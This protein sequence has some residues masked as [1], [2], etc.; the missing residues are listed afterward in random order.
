MSRDWNSS[1]SGLGHQSECVAT[2]EAGYLAFGTTLVCLQYAW[3]ALPAPAEYGLLNLKAVIF[4]TATFAWRKSYS[5]LPAPLLNLASI[6]RALQP[7]FIYAK[8]LSHAADSADV[9]PPSAASLQQLPPMLLPCRTIHTRLVPSKHSFSYSYLFVGVPVLETFSMNSILS[10]DPASDQ[11]S[12][13][14]SIHAEDY[15]ARGRHARGLRGKLDEYL[16]SLSLE[17]KDYRHA[18]LVTAPRFLGF[19]FNP[20]S[21]WY[22]YS[23]GMKLKAMI[24]EVNNTFDE[25]RLYFLPGALDSNSKTKFIDQWRKDFHVSPFNDRE[26]S[27]SMTAAD[28]FNLSTAEQTVDNNIVLKSQDGKPKLVA[29]V[30][31]TSSG[32]PAASLNKTQTLVFVLRWCWVGFMTNPRILKEARKL[33]MRK[34]LDLFYRPEIERTSIG[35]NATVEET[36]IEPYFLTYLQ[37]LSNQTGQGFSYISAAGPQRGSSIEVAPAEATNNQDTEVIEI[38]VLTP[39]WYSALA[40]STDMRQTWQLFCFDAV[41]GKA[42]IYVTNADLMKELVTRLRHSPEHI[43]LR[44]EYFAG[45]L[46]KQLHPGRKLL[47]A[48]LAALTTPWITTTSVEMQQFDM[49]FEALVDDYAKSSSEYIQYLFVAV[50]VLLA[51]RLALSLT[52]LLQFYGRTVWLV[53]VLSISWQCSRLIIQEERLGAVVVCK[54]LVETYVL[55]WSGKWARGKQLF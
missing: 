19:S 20:V 25:R 33:W 55:H 43:S 35:R 49:S 36:V 44:N 24:L 41:K 9:G 31:S 15:L 39:E 42:L 27:Y 8:T 30:L 47:P 51:D 1:S 46:H 11:P 23:E 37:E 18:Y 13:W 48:I 38:N 50:T 10:A 45:R 12:T 7:C 4:L 26:G 22:L 17:P 16:R 28:P 34:K 40:R 53:A 14:F 6:Y 3:S 32:V 21:F 52:S 2:D 5:I 29:R 54:M